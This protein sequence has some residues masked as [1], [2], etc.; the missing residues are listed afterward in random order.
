MLAANFMTPLL[1]KIETVKSVVQNQLDDIKRLSG[2]NSLILSVCL[3]D[4]LAGFFCG[5]TGQKKGNKIRYLQFVERYL[6]PYKD[7]LY[8]IR[9]N[10]THSFSNTISNFMFVDNKEFTSVF[11]DTTQILDYPIFNIDKFKDDLA[12]A[13][14]LYFEE[15]ENISSTEIHKNF[16]SRFDSLNI[17]TD[18]FLPTLRNIKGEIVKD[19][20]KLDSLLGLDLKIA[21]ASP[22]KVKK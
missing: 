13:I 16:N 18:T 15:L 22:T 10:L 19:Y 9:C 1:S 11:K 5:Y 17:L 20:D 4:T 21:I 3:V 8:E 7:Y 2:I 14:N 12:N 6:Q